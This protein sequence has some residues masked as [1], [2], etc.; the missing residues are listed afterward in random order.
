MHSI[1]WKEI[2]DII[3]E[4]IADVDRHSGRFNTVNISFLSNIKKIKSYHNSHE[5]LQRQQ[6][7]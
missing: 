4:N 5:F 6:S 7:F 3:T 1:A 2:K